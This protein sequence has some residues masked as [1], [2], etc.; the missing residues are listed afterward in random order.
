MAWRRPGWSSVSAT[1]YLQVSG[2]C[3]V[4]VGGIWADR[5]SRRRP[6]ARA[7]VAAIGFLLCAPGLFLTGVAPALSW[8]VLGLLVF[9]VGRGL[10]DSNCMPIL[11]QIVPQ[12]LSATGYGFMNL[13]SCAAGGLI[14]Y[15]SGALLD[16]GVSLT[17]VF[18]CAA[19]G[20][21]VGA[22][23]LALLVPSKQH[24]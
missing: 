16:A 17:I 18:K 8:A 6:A 3:S 4:F 12:R 1:G 22:L 7:W 13:F 5:W 20:M 24:E 19:G 2:F 15:G 23:G 9:G 21:A 10:F 11:R 14:A